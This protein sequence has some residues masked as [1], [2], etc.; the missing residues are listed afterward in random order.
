[1]DQDAIKNA[2][3]KVATVQAA[4]DEAQHVLQ[5][6]EK[7][8]QVAEESAKVMRTV[9]LAAIAGLVLL[10]LTLATRRHHR[11]G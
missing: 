10:A 9:A 3:A 2:E 5:A 7:A 6:A 1:M 11:A 8:Q 4:L